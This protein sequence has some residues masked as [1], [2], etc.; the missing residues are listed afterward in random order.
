MSTQNLEEYLKSGSMLQILFQIS[1]HRG[2]RKKKKIIGNITEDI[3]E[4]KL[5]REKI[6]NIGVD[7]T[8]IR[9]IERKKIVAAVIWPPHSNFPCT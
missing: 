6:R 5:G 4:H 7:S 2:S 3:S 9:K 8:K 1:Y